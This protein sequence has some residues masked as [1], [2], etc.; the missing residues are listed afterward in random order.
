[1][2]FAPN[3]RQRTDYNDLNAR[4]MARLPVDLDEEEAWLTGSINSTALLRYLATDAASDLLLVM[5]YPFGLSYMTC[6]LYGPRTVLV[7]CLHPEGY[8]VLAH[9]AEMFAR[10]GGM[11]FNSPE[12]Q[13]LALRLHPTIA[14]KPMAVAG[15]GLDDPPPVDL[16]QLERWRRTRTD[17]RPYLLYLGWRDSTKGF[18]FL[19][20]CYTAMAMA[21]TS[22]GLV[23]PRLLMAGPGQVEIPRA[24]TSC[25]R[26][27]GYI[28]DEEKEMALASADWLV[29]PSRNES[30]SFVMMEA[31]RRATPCLVNGL[32]EVTRGHVERANGGLWFTNPDDMRAIMTWARLNPTRRQALGLQGRDFVRREMRWDAIVP[33]IEEVLGAVAEGAGL[34]RPGAHLRL[35]APGLAADGLEP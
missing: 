30:F 26:D 35:A 20:H 34:Q 23:P 13:E 31:W 1:V 18:D 28:D 15:A 3:R 16:P 2:R 19:M 6:Y 12:E 22:Q 10:A 14:A 4:I 21:K 33:R 8:A 27:L 24:L 32:C 17:G 29:Q 9:T 11:L 25:I 7:P 5:P